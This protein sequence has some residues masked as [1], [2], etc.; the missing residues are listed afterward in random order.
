MPADDRTPRRRRR[1]G[2]AALPVLVVEDPGASPGA[3]VDALATLLLARA[4][5]VLAPDGDQ[6]PTSPAG[7]RGPGRESK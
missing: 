7:D 5:R 1:P 3:L 4:R 6:R 2:P